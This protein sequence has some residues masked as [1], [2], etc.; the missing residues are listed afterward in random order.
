[1]VGRDSSRNTSGQIRNSLPNRKET[2]SDNQMRKASSTVGQILDGATV[3]TLVIAA[4]LLGASFIVEDEMLGVFKKA[5]DDVAAEMSEKDPDFKCAWTSLRAFRERYKIWDDLAPLEVGVPDDE[6][7]EVLEAGRDAQ[8]TIRHP[9]QR[10]CDRRNGRPGHRPG[11][12]LQ[13]VQDE[14]DAAPPL[15]LRSSP[16]PG[17]RR[18]GWP[19]PPP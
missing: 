7:A 2:E 8:P 19:A 14:H 18:A 6:R 10:E 5:W 3:V 9:Q 12:R 4:L 17:A 13:I 15:R 11:I 1:M 16:R